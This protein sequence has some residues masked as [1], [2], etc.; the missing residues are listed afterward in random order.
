MLDTRWWMLAAL[1]CGAA[2]GAQPS[3]GARPAL[4]NSVRQYVAI[5]TPV[6][7]LTHVR[8]IDGTG[9]PARENQTRSLRVLW[10]PSDPLRC[11]PR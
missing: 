1:C 10:L 6:V 3:R 11:T 5:D 4:A 2:V 9:A 7:A 8:I